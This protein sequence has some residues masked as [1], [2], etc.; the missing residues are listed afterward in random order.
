[1]ASEIHHEQGRNFRVL[2]SRLLNRLPRTFHGF[3]SDNF[4]ISRTVQDPDG[5]S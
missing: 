2:L 1:M 3:R 5:G 4:L